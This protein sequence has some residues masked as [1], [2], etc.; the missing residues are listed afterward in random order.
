[1]TDNKKTRDEIVRELK[2]EDWRPPGLIS[3]VRARN[4]FNEEVDRRLAEQEAGSQSD[5]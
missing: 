4:A 2:D 1:M 5:D 3:I